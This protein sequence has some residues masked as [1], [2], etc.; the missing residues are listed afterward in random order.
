MRL[1]VI[2]IN[3][4]SAD[5]R[6]RETLALV[7]QKLFGSA[8]SAHS[9]L[10]YVLLST[11]NRTEVYFYSEDP[12]ATHTYLLNVLRGEI[13]EEFEHRIYSYFGSDCFFHL[14]RVTAGVDSALLGETEIQG[15][16]KRAYET[17]AEYRAL[18]RELHFLFQKC[19]KI[20]KQVRSESTLYG[21]SPS[22]EESILQA[23]EQ[24]FEN[25]SQKKV[26]FVG[27]SEINYK[28]YMGFKKR[29]FERITFCNRS[30]HK[31][32]ELELNA[33][34]WKRLEQWTGYDVVI[35]GTKSPCFLVSTAEVDSKKLVID[36]SVPRNVDPSIGRHAH[37]M[38]LNVDQ[39]NRRATKDKRA[40]AAE[41]VRIE[42]Q[43]IAQA[44]EK[45]VMIFKIKE[46]QRSSW[47][48]SNVS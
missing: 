28:V 34:P 2:G 40:K 14:A 5:L 11:C 46:L 45:Q 37:V 39:L 25:L 48:L 26:L 43:L 21:G 36:L 27:L 38:L 9:N 31:V 20:G 4:K 44:V 7:S 6:L 42:T 8:N 30:D 29:G 10:S 1:G 16:V 23:G 22:L 17:A 32:Q 24:V 12:A 33:L 47:V 18:A 35:F 13:Q 15:Q 19:L 41:V 3:H